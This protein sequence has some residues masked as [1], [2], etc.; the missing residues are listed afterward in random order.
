MTPT[1]GVPEVLARSRTAVAPALSEAIERLAPEIRRL[2]T[3][4][5][6]WTDPGGNRSTPRAARASVP[7]WPSCP[8]KRPGPTRRWGCPARW[9][10]S[11][12]ITSR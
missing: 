4:H 3:Y 2:A 1:I 8:R 6:G 10:W 7:P 11:W 12:S 5:M 9:R